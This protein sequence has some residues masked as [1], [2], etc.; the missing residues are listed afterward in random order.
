MSGVICDVEV[1]ALVFAFRL[2]L[3]ARGARDRA[4]PDRM[5][6]SA[7]IP[8][9]GYCGRRRAGTCGCGDFSAGKAHSRGIA[10]FRRNG[11]LAWT[12]PVSY[13]TVFGSAAFSA[14]LHG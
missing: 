3:A 5:A 2:L 7:A 10:C 11:Q 1:F 8:R 12:S 6:A 13:R 4:L 9:G 14:I